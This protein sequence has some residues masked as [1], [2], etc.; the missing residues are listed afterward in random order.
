VTF[1]VVLVVTGG[2]VVPMTSI[3]EEPLTGSTAVVEA[4]AISVVVEVLLRV[5]VSVESDAIDVI[6]TVTLQVETGNSTVLL[7]VGITESS[8][9]E[10]LM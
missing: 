3:V 2:V 4:P 1:P 6:V 10:V 7:V 5:T 8:L 9:L